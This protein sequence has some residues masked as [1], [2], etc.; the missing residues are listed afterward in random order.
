MKINKILSLIIMFNLIGCNSISTSANVSTQ[1]VN[2]SNLEVIYTNTPS[3]TETTQGLCAQTAITQSDLNKCASQ[4]AQATH[5]KLESLIDELQGR[6][7]ASQY[8]LL[9]NIEAD[10]QRTASK[11]CEWEV[12]FF[13]GGS[14]QPMWLADCLNRQYLDRIETLRLTL[15]EGN[16]MTGEC[17]ESLKYKE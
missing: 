11:H 8:E 1:Q 16:G 17:E 13:D 14:I 2:I 5:S 4:N 12:S 7:N 6:M 9:L 3:V 10:W 15:C